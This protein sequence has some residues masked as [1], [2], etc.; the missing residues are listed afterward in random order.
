[1]HRVNVITVVVAE[2]DRASAK[3]P[4]MHSHHEAYSVIK[5]EF[6]EYWTE[7][8]KGGSVPRDPAALRRELIETAAMCFRALHDL[9]AA[10]EE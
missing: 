7:V 1:M 5:E 2:F 9:C 4:P 10:E 6:E 3:H 8:K